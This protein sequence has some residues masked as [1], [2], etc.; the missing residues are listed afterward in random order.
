M[1]FSFNTAWVFVY[2]IVNVDYVSRC[3]LHYNQSIIFLYKYNV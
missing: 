3:H 1:I 2:V